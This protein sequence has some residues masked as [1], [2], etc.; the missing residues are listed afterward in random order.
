MIR[1]TE[2]INN[3]DFNSRMERTAQ[4]KFSLGEVWINEQFVVNVRAAPGYKKLLKEGHL[5]PELDLK[6]EFTAITTNNG[7]LT[8]THVVVGDLTTVATRLNR[9]SRSLLKG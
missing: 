7:G 3:T 5:S 8:E 2:V 9:D 4:L 1:F 6:H